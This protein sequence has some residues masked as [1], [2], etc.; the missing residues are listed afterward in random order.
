MKKYTKLYYKAFGFGLMDFVACEIC[1]AKAV[2][3]HHID[4]RGMGGTDKDDI[5]NLMALCRGCHIEYGDK[6]HYKEFLKDRHLKY[7]DIN[8]L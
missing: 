5:K 6:K 2:D 1:G 8:G 3:I 7:M 4:A